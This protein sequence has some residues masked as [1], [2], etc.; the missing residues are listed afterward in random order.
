MTISA[1]IK[2][3]GSKATNASNPI[4]YMEQ[5]AT[6]EYFAQLTDYAKKRFPD[7]PLWE[8]QEPKSYRFK[9]CILTTGKGKIYAIRGIE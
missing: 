4:A 2:T 5:K 1:A 7:H 9:D 6:Q 3:I 8:N